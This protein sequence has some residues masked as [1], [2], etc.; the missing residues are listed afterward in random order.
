MTK[1][2]CPLLVSILIEVASC[3]L[4]AE[5]AD[6]SFL[7]AWTI[8]ASQTAPWAAAGQKP[9]TSDLM[10]L[11]NKTVTFSADRIDA[12]RPLTCRKPHYEM[13]AYAP[14]MLFQGTLSDPARQAPSLGFTGKT[15]PTLETG[16]E[17]MLDFHFVDPTRAMFGLNNR[18]YVLT[19]STK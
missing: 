12:P 10:A 9:V 16:C 2:S 19:R 11:M 14:D 3:V 15:I 18:V 5:A 13:K 6:R 17:G 4:P 1:L 7:G 8:T